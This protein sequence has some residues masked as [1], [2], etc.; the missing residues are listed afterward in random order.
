MRAWLKEKHILEKPS[1][2]C[3]TRHQCWN[4]IYEAAKRLIFVEN[5]RLIPIHNYFKNHNMIYI[6]LYS[7][8][9]IGRPYKDLKDKMRNLV[10]YSKSAF[11]L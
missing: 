7:V 8:S 5:L 9:T 4:N 1:A 6:P 3:E 11:L 2:T 10:K